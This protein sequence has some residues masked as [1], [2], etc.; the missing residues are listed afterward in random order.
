MQKFQKKK[1]TQASN[2]ILL[3]F[4]SYFHETLTFS[5]SF[6]NY[7]KEP[8]TIQLSTSNYY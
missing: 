4:E 5:T 8:K 7:I 2:A 1:Y 3:W 6:L